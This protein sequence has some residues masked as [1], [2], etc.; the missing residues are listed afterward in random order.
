MSSTAQTI[1]LLLPLDEVT[2]CPP[3]NKKV[4]LPFIVGLVD[5]SPVVEL[6]ENAL[7]TSLL[8]MK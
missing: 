3:G 8:P 4:K 7:R 2:G 6:R 5:S 1:P